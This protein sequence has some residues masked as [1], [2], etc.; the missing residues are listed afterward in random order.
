[1]DQGGIIM[2]SLFSDEMD[3]SLNLRD[4]STRLTLTVRDCSPRILQWLTTQMELFIETRLETKYFR[5]WALQKTWTIVTNDEIQS[6]DL[7]VSLAAVIDMMQC[8]VSSDELI[9]SQLPSAWMTQ[10]CINAVITSFLSSATAI[11]CKK[12]NTILLRALSASQYSSLN[13][14]T[15][16]TSSELETSLLCELATC[17]LN[18][19]LRAEFKAVIATKEVT[20]DCERNRKYLTVLNIIGRHWICLELTMVT[21]KGGEKLVIA[22]IYD[23]G[24]GEVKEY[25][26]ED[27]FILFMKDLAAHLVSVEEQCILGDEVGWNTKSS[28]LDSITMTTTIKCQLREE[29]TFRVQ[30]DDFSCGP[31][32]L[33]HLMALADESAYNLPSGQILRRM[34]DVSIKTISRQ[35]ADNLVFGR[36]RPALTGL[37]LHQEKL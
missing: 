21:P 3:N 20:L 32:A 30:Q 6:R 17:R 7:E 5:A 11:Q 9:R 37:D 13:A 26:M 15:C 23:S 16:C 18:K 29:N 24:E 8:C 14:R 28:K 36:E 35:L 1:M 25:L 22:K 10:S 2:I 4:R 33:F 27:T 19:E 12:S 31:L 34:K